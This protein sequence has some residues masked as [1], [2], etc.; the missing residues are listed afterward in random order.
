MQTEQLDVVPAWGHLWLG[1]N[2]PATSP[3][4]Q[5]VSNTELFRRL[6]RA[7][8]FDQ[9]ELHLSD[10]EQIELALGDHVD[11]AALRSEGF[12]RVS[13]HP[14][15]HLPYADGRF[16]TPSGKAE[17]VAESFA[18]AGASTSS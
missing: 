16:H 11:V 17:L 4:G 8:G 15:D 2:E 10:E 1:W 13:N 18:A 14:V 3:R 9:P 7:F 12:V 5:S 6:A